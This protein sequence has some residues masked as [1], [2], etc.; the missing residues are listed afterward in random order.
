M[1]LFFCSLNGP[2]F[3]EEVD[4]FFQISLRQH[5]FSNTIISK[6]FDERL[7]CVKTVLLDIN[8][9][10]LSCLAINSR[11]L[12]HCVLSVSFFISSSGSYF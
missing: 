9:T 1:F 4:C 5:N 6:L 2:F 12:N 10:E 11:K 7:F 3:I 8:L